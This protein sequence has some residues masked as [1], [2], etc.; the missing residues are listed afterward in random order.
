MT[1]DIKQEL[2]S[3]DTLTLSVRIDLIPPAAVATKTT[4]TPQARAP[5]R[6]Q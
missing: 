6:M 5:R 4:T 3:G 2:L 1:H